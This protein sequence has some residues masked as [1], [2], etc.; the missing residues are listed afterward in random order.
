MIVSTEFGRFSAPFENEGGFLRIARSDGDVGEMTVS[1][2]ATI[3]IT[4]G[5]AESAPGLQ[6]ARNPGSVGTVTVQGSGTLIDIFQNGPE[7]AFLGGPFLQVG[8]SGAGTMFI[9]DFA[10]VRLSG[11]GSIVQVSRGN[12]DQGGTDPLLAQSTL[13]ILSGGQLLVD[14]VGTK[15]ILNIGQE[16]NG[17][18][19]VVVSGP[20]SLLSILGLGS[21][22][23]V[24][25]DGTG[26]LTVDQGGLVVGP[27]FLQ[28]G[29]FVG[30][31]GTV[32]VDGATS[33]INLSGFDETGQGAFMNAGWEGTGSVNVLNGATITI[34]G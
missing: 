5:L 4:G 20:D 19:A 15:V 28:S 29:F 22:I 34:N 23:R 16:A 3:Q 12:T 9:Q 13:S 25:R 14:G 27:T 18:G 11:Q 7:D 24:G 30:S 33:A 2:G 10:V 17:H 21:S 31:D 32:T 8:R 6:I 26:S 1:D